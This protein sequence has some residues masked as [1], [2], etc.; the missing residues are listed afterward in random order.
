[1]FYNQMGDNFS[2]FN[3]TVNVTPPTTGTYE[4]ISFWQPRADAMEIHLSGTANV[5]MTGTMYNVGNSYT[6]GENGNSSDGEF[7][8]NPSAGATYNFGNYICDQ[9]E[10]QQLIGSTGGTIQMNPGTAHATQRPII[11][12]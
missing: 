3:G 4:G 7:D 11:V 2:P 10:W 9:A 12:E 1:M 8:I 6:T 5:S